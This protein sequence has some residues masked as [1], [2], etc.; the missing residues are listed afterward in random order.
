M[1]VPRDTAT[2]GAT[3]ARAVRRHHLL[4]SAGVAIIGVVAAGFSPAAAT[5]FGTKRVL[6]ISS[7]RS[8]MPAM[9]ELEE[10]IRGVFHESAD[11]EIELFPEYFDF[12]RFPIEQYA[13]ANVQY[14]RER[15]AGQGIDLI[16]VTTGFALEF[17][18]SHRDELFPKTP[19]VFCAAADREI[20]RPQ[21]PPDVT[22][23]NGHFDIERT[24]KLIFRLQPNVTEIVCVGGTSDFDRFWE[25]ETRK[26]LERFADRTRFRWI[27][28][29]SLNQTAHELSK[30]PP[31]A[32]VFYISMLRDGEGHSMTATDAVRDLCRV[33]KAPVYGFTS[34]F[35][36]AGTVGGAVFDFGVN[37][38]NA[39][40]L[41][42]KVLR[43]EWVPVGSPELETRNPLVVNWKALKKWNLSE[44]RVP[45]GAEI[46]HKPASLWE[47]HRTL[48]LWTVFIVLIQS[49]LI[50]GWVAQRLWRRR[51]E[52]SLH[53]SEKRFR[54]LADAAPVL[55]WMAGTDKLCIFV[56]EAWLEFT[57]RT[58][59]QELGNG[60]TEGIH[61]D[62]A[63]DCLK[64]YRAAFDAREAFVLEYRLKH[65]DGE[66]RWLTDRGVPRYDAAGGFLGYIGACVDTT[67]LRE[68]E[69]ALHEFE[70]RVTLAAEA[71]HLGVWELDTKTNEFWISDN[72]RQLFQFEPDVRVT[73]AMIQQRIHPE[74]RA[75]RDAA[76][77]NAI[78][79]KG[80]YEME[81][82]ALLPDKSVRWIGARAR[83]VADPDGEM[84]RLLGVSMDVTERKQ[85]EQFL[86]L[87]AEASHLGV[88]DWDETTGKLSSD[89]ATREIFD[90]PLEGEV[91][92][93]TFY[94]AIYPHDLERVKQVWRH[95]VESGLPYELEYRVQKSNGVIRWVHA[96]GHGF[97]DDQGKPLRMI[98]IV[99]DITDRK[100]AEEEAQR[101][102]DQIEL[103]S[104]VSLLGE[105]TASIA[106]ELNQPLSGITSNASAAQ[107]F[108]DRGKVD[109]A[110]LRE[111][112]VDIGADGRR[113]SDIIKHI[114]NTIKKGAALREH[115]N[116]NELAGHVAHMLQPDARMHSCELTLSLAKDLPGIEGDPVQIQQVLINLVSNAFEAM[117]GTLP[118]QRKVEIATE[119]NGEG[120]VQMS[121]R[122]HGVGISE[123]ARERMF[124]QFFTTK[125]EGLGMGLAIVR[126]II[127][128]HGGKISA[129][130]MN[131][132]GARFYFVLP[133]AE[134]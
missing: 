120:T 48:I 127:E 81:Y 119:K 82:R 90:V 4:I 6:F 83:C 34:H 102:R 86:Q 79:T 101:R 14:L 130:N 71:A 69:N 105:T 50:V 118:D 68:K 78:K 75:S 91:T 108:I 2:V 124:E 53:E 131:G 39:A 66:F 23:I 1:R 20:I 3:T 38:R 93:D 117:N 116:L 28:D 56:N 31:S 112:L 72:A 21:L 123:Q 60:W 74:D 8:D 104:R 64:T 77:Q 35:V 96:R 15:Y 17:V 122:D 37:G 25:E 88:W 43:G 51:A 89:S 13:A 27:A 11:P 36:D 100:Q 125:E 111:I 54:V 107:R 58:M 80:G 103:L 44:S 24:L 65:H 106:H 42:L 113:A 115:I 55:M 109:L 67:E 98:G 61:P 33:S 133:T 57:G 49:A 121:V 29:E 26:V 87:A 16:L 59:E 73:Y 18:L 132:G 97:Y 114:R 84:T 110:Q 52:L 99:L 95:A 41:A 5:Q 10:T 12:A 46:R 40:N 22:G 19:I 134:K 70:E 128:A 62:D 85:T 7:E 9:R 63:D 30:L 94:R 129:E 32:A 45:A 47:T 126:S 76:A 92:L